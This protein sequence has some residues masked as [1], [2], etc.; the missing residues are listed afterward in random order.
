MEIGTKWRELIITGR[1]FAV[2]QQNE[3]LEEKSLS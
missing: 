2:Q 3:S 1:F